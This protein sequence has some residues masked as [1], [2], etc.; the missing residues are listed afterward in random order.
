[1]AVRS[2]IRKAVNGIRHPVLAGR[3]LSRAA[4]DG[5][6]NVAPGT[7]AFFK[8]ILMDRKL[9][10]TIAEAAVKGVATR[11]V[12]DIGAR[13]GWWS[14]F[15][16]RH[17]PA[18]FILFEA[19]DE[20]AP[21]LERRGFRFFTGILSD[22]ERNV[23]WYGKGETGDSYYRENTKHYSDVEATT[24][25]TSTLDAVIAANDLP[26]PDLIKLDTQGSE[27][28]ILNGGQRALSHASFV[29]IE[30]SLVDYNA[31][32]PQLAEVIEYMNK[33]DFI[34]CDLGE[35][36]RKNGALIQ[37]DILFIRRVAYKALDASTS[38][39][40]Y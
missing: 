10:R 1:M 5:L 28:D 21:L 39:L 31:G 8:S 35:E 33:H 23:V 27:L 24:K 17:I 12:Y 9:P 16:N 6:F 36:H 37:L 14:E 15:M 3:Y 29:Y 25:R 11:V 22:R 13:H 4:I 38:G 2:A 7:E 34:P 26:L 32:A 40:H 18:E 20:H 19:N 30:C